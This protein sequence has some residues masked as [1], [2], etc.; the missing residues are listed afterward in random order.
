MRVLAAILGFI[1]G[2]VA[3]YLV[4]VTGAFWY[5]R[6]YNVH[7]RDGGMSMA[8][9]FAI[10]PLAGLA[11]GILSA[12][13]AAV[14]FGRRKRGRAASEL[15][16]PKPWP[17]PALILGSLAAGAVV[18]F[19]LWTVLQISGPL[20]FDSYAAALAFWLVTVALAF[21]VAGVVLWRGL[22]RRARHTGS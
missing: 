14:W 10:G 13:I 6:A 8:I 7:D 17:L 12:V 11:G 18:Y 3:V 1:I 22:R 5:M 16:P 9:M 20:R 2:F 4:T 19:G 15:P 21:C